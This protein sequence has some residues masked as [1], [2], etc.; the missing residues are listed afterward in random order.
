MRAMS[1]EVFAR[2]LPRPE[3]HTESSICAASRSHI[4]CLGWPLNRMGFTTEAVL[5]A[6]CVFVC[7]YGAV[8][9]SNGW[10]ACFPLRMHSNCERGSDEIE[11]HIKKGEVVNWNVL[12]CDLVLFIAVKWQKLCSLD[13]R[14]GLSNL[15]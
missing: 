15:Q 5:Y 9:E 12:L 3:H 14:S 11:N 13:L 8:G 4:Y 6:I 1:F 7:V 10:D 2:L